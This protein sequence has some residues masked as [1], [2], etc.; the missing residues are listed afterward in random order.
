MGEHGL[1]GFVHLMLGAH[2]TPS[3]VVSYVSIYARPVDCWSGKQ[4]HPPR[5]FMHVMKICQGP[6]VYLWGMHT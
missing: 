1:Y 4:L 3:N 5:V 2:S 6:V